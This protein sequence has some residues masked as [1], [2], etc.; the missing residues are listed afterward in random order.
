MKSEMQIMRFYLVGQISSLRSIA[1]CYKTRYSR[2]LTTWIYQQLLIPF[3]I[4]APNFVLQPLPFFLK[5]HFDLE[6]RYWT[7][8]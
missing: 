2:K 3:N 6:Q 5:I 4:I 8:M 1:C 7:V